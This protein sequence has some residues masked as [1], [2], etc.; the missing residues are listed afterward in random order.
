MLRAAMND[1]EL[2]ITVVG[3]GAEV[4]RRLFGT[5]LERF[6]KGAG[7]FATTADFESEAAMLAVLGRER[8][9]DAVLGEESG[10]GGALDGLRLWLLD[11]LCGTL[12]YAA[13]MPVVSVNAAVVAAE[14]VLAAAVAEP[15]GDE[16][17]WTDGSSAFVRTQGRDT[18]LLPSAHS[19]LVDLNLDPPF[20]NAPAFQAAALAAD[21]EFAAR[22]MPRVVAS[23][24]ALTWVATGQ[25]CAYITDGDVR[26][27]VHFAAGLGICGAAGCCISDLRG[28]TWGQGPDGL[29]VA[30]D[31]P[32]H[33]ALLALVDRQLG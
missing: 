19:G 28:G 20:P 2:A 13:R 10:R 23:S 7:D 17:F 32:T 24:L 6:D 30:A 22:F 31:R 15:F 29:I 14:A 12:N 18:P 25:R 8:P 16:V 3:A 21:S 27:S 26:D 11:P 1:P 5:P 9:A 33:A 4:V